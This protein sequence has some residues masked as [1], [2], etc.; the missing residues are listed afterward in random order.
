VRA[1]S[2]NRV[3][4]HPG[5]IL[6]EEFLSPLG[7]TQVELARHIGVSLRRVNEIIRGKRGVTPATALCLADALE[8]TPESWM[9]LQSNFDLAKAAQASERRK[10]SSMRKKGD[11]CVAVAASRGR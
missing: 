1:I 7:I 2:Q 4:T 5:E 10:I 9:N 11:R 8:T 6:L 3:P